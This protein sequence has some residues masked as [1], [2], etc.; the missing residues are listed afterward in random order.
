MHEPFKRISAKDVSRVQVFHI[1]EL[2]ARRLI[3]IGTKAKNAVDAKLLKYIV[4]N[5]K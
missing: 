4:R 3:G 5:T 2:N 1:A